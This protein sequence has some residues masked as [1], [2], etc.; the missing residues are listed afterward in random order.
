MGSTAA[1]PWFPRYGRKGWCTEATTE[2]AS[3]A[4]NGT[5]Y[6]PVEDTMVE[7]CMSVEREGNLLRNASR[8]RKG[9]YV[10]VGVGVAKW[11]RAGGKQRQR[12]RMVCRAVRTVA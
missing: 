3:H 2:R 1:N 4:I 12:T 8:P 9:S 5:F 7:G 6:A 10:A 11:R